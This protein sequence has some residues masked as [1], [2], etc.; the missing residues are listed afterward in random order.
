M[1]E[2]AIPQEVLL[3]AAC[4][5]WPLSEAAL[6][7][8]R[9]AASGPIDWPLFM[10]VVR[11]HRVVGL[12]HHALGAAHIDV[13]ADIALDLA[14]RAENIAR[15]AMRLAGET[16]RLQRLFDAERIPTV[17]LKGAAVAQLAYGTLGLKQAFDIDLLVPSDRA[18]DAFRMLEKDGYR[19][20]DPASELDDAQWR[21]V[22]RFG[23]EVLAVDR[24]RD[25][26]VELRW[27]AA[28]NM[29]LFKGVDLFAHTIGVALSE[30]SSLRT[31]DD[32]NQFAYLCVHGARHGWYRLKWL[33]DLNALLASK[34]DATIERLFAHAQSIGSGLCAGLALLLCNELLALKLPQSLHGQLQKDW[35]LRLAARL[36]LNLMIGSQ[37][38]MEAKDRPRQLLAFSLTVLPF[39]LGS[40]L[41]Y[42]IRQAW[43]ISVSLE[44]VIKYPMPSWLYAL[45]PILRGPLWI[46]RSVS[47]SKRDIKPERDRANAGL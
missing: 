44:D 33:A 14:K 10:R 36:A 5:R 4:C 20:R 29:M 11:R 2:R 25:L 39:L 3:V 31:F 7:A 17:V 8:I 26:T 37:P 21:G 9:T 18:R 43:I 38:D 13:P 19:L 35:R 23:S 30:G 47:S 12:V 32:N 1:S 15:Q 6:A 24:A 22:M 41:R 45:Y 28:E 34:D 46:C 16:L 40:G 27:R 42:F